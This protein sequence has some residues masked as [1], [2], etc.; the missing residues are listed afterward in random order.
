MQV[1][2][3][4]AKPKIKRP[5]PRGYRNLTAST[6]APP[7]G[8]CLQA[9]P[10]DAALGPEVPLAFL[11]YMAYGESFLPAGELLSLQR[12]K[13]GALALA[14]LQPMRGTLTFLLFFFL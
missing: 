2:F 10:L 6:T 5:H 7:V 13:L 12:G 9:C 1:L 3:N 14:I 8:G 11:P 4:H